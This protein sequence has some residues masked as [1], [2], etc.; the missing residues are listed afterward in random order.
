MCMYRWVETHALWHTIQSNQRLFSCHCQNPACVGWYL[1]PVWKRYRDVVWNPF[2]VD[3]SWDGIAVIVSL[4]ASTG[5]KVYPQ[6]HNP[7][8][9]LLSYSC[10]LPHPQTSWMSL[11]LSI[12][13]RDLVHANEQIGTTSSCAAW[14]S[15]F[16]TGELHGQMR[17]L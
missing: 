6:T 7:G 9:K 1:W 8:W 3:I 2:H 11:L 15:C 17:L 14:C 4:H 16:D 10:C 5:C 12:V 13:T